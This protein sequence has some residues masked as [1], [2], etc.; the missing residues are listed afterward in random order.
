[1]SIHDH[2]HGD[3]PSCGRSATVARPSPLW[4]LAL[5]PAWIAC[6]AMVVASSMLGFGL[7]MVAPFVLAGGACLLSALHAKASEEPVCLACGKIARWDHRDSKASAAARSS[8]WSAPAERNPSAAAR[9]SVEIRSSSAS[10][11]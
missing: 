4:R 2:S 7:L 5:V 6:A 8:R 9:A 1:M 10:A 11:A 3:C